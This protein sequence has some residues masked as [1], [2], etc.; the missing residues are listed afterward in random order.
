[1]IE[2]VYPEIVFPRVIQPTKHQ[3]MVRRSFHAV[4]LWVQIHIVGIGKM[5]GGEGRKRPELKKSEFNWSRT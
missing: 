5:W 2:R 4:N 3:A 1:L